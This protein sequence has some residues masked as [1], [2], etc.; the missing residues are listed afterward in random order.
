MPC[1]PCCATTQTVN[2]PGA[3]GSPGGNG[4]NGINAFSLTTLGFATPA[5]NAPVTISVTSTSWMVV[6][7][8]VIVGQGAAVLVNPGPAHFKV[9]SI[10]SLTSVT[11]TFL[12]YSG[13]VAALT[14]I[15]SGATICPAGVQSAFP[16][17]SKGDLIVDDGATS[18]S[19]DP[20][21]LAVGND[22]RTIFADSTQALGIK[23]AGASQTL[24]VNTTGV[25]TG[26]L[27]Q[28]YDLQTFTIPANTLLNNGDSIHF[29]ALFE[30]A[31]N[32]NTKES[33]IFFG[34]T[35]VGRYAFAGLTAQNGGTVYI[36]G[37]IIRTGAATQRWYAQVTGMTAAGVGTSL[38]FAGTAA[39]NNGAGII[40]KG[41][42][43]N[44][45]ASADVTQRMFFLQY[46]SQ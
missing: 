25:T 3:P 11:L 42:G 45:A 5:I 19:P 18:P 13:D 17:T 23:Y 36:R 37:R 16:T 14:T 29:E 26:V 12:H 44:G 10:N 1:T 8:Y 35:E 43:T 28:A 33:Q 6:G 15:D 20:K 46:T 39:E 22:G 31:A 21:R 32:G 41:V 9:T 7:Q 4:T 30:Y 40:I 38:N 27:A 34:A 2:V 24:N